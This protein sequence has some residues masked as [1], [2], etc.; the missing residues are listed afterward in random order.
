MET[1]TRNYIST[2]ERSE[3]GHTNGTKTV[4]DPI[5]DPL[6]PKQYIR[7]GCWNVGTLYQ[8]GKLAQ[9]VNEMK[10]YNLSLLVM[11]EV[12][13]IGT[14]KQRLNSGEVI[15]WSGRH[16]YDNYHE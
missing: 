14:G 16:A 11:S 4:K 7:V 2:G 12:R 10:Q 3:A 5:T 1:T 9:A 15:I 6:T 13:W 8:T